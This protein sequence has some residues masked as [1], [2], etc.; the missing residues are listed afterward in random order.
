MDTVKIGKFLKELR[1]E[2][3]FTQ[4]QLGE[5]ISVTNKTISRWENGN[6]MPPIECL[7]MLSDIYKISINEIV[8]GERVTEDKIKEVAEENISSVLTDLQ[9]KNRK[10]ENRMIITL[11]VSTLLTI[12]VLLLL[13]LDSMKNVLIFIMIIILAFIKNTLNIVAL[14]AK[15]ESSGR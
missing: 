15:K 1:K 11:I 13:P 12:A 7:E 2:K 3:G 9:N 5:K 10:F 8:A 14:V 6:Y 4:E